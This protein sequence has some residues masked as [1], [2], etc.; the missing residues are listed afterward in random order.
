MKIFVEIQKSIVQQAID[1]KS[2][3]ELQDVIC[4]NIW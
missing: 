1:A 3:D 4:D 2:W